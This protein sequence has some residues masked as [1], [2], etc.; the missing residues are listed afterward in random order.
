MLS[1][2]GV[3]C[4]KCDV[5][6]IGTYTHAKDEFVCTL[7][8]YH[9]KGKVTASS[10][11]IFNC[12]FYKNHGEE[13]LECEKCKNNYVLTESGDCVIDTLIQNCQ[14]ALSSSKCL[15]CKPGFVINSGSCFVQT[16]SNCQ[17]YLKNDATSVQ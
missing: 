11:F 8:P 2:Y 16:D 13:T 9:T 1:D 6:F 14:H 7:S 15:E 10:N 4:H 12:Q 5:G 17:T 3:G